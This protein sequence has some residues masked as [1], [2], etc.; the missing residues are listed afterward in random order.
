MKIACIVPTCRDECIKQF[1]DGWID[2]FA[3]NDVL[4][5]VVKD[6]RD[7]RVFY[8]KRNF[9]VKDIMGDKSD[10]IYNKNDGVR[11]LGFACVAKH[12]PDIEYYMTLDDDVLP[13]GDTIKNHFNALNKRVPTSWFNIASDYTRGF[14]YRLREESEVVLSHGVWNGIMDFDAPTQLVNGNK[15]LEFYNGPI[16]KG[17]YFQ[18]CGMNLMFKK[19]LLPYMYFAPMGHRVGL[20]R[21]ADIWLGI[22]VKR[23]IDDNGWAV[24]SGY[25]KVIHNK[26]SNVFANLIKES[27]GLMLNEDYWSG[28]ESDPYFKL[29]NSQRKKWK[30]FINNL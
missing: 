23:A 1:I 27:K 7:P 6:G 12:F 5:V 25:S 16:P 4:L 2:L 21:F 24:V 20:D 17:V 11:N 30:D 10:L 22:N 8:K 9:S 18:M 14:P 15:Q 3:K 29:Y 26:A 13:Y 28:N 19:K